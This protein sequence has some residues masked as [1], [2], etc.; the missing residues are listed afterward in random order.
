MFVAIHRK[1]YLERILIFIG[2]LNCFVHRKKDFS[3][4]NC[5]AFFLFNIKDDKYH[6]KDFL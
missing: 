2:T 1:N 5:N 4:K 3:L 6:F